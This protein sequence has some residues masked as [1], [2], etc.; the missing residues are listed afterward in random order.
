[1]L[2]IILG[3]SDGGLCFGG[4]LVGSLMAASPIQVRP[5][6]PVTAVGLLNISFIVNYTPSSPQNSM[7]ARQLKLRK[8]GL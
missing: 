1:M 4:G 7:K 6:F 5:W 8:W 3:N 2:S